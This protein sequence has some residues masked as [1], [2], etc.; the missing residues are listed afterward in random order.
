MYVSL[1]CGTVRVHRFIDVFLYSCLSV[2][3]HINVLPFGPGHCL[4]HNE[5]QTVEKRMISILVNPAAEPSTPLL[6]SPIPSLLAPPSLPPSLTL[7]ASLPPNPC[8]SQLVSAASLCRRASCKRILQCGITMATAMVSDIRSVES[9]TFDS[10]DENSN[11]RAL[12]H[13]K[14]S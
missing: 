3:V 2:Y 11:F 12:V 6:V 10:S 7:S 8:L 14:T 9:G 1:A 5:G 13:G 4:L